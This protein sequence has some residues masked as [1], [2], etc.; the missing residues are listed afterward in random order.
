M[1]API[2]KFFSAGEQQAVYKR[3]QQ[4]P[5]NMEDMRRER[6]HS[7]SS[8]FEQVHDACFD[9]CRT[10]NDLT[11]LSVKEGRCY[12]NCVTK[13][14]Y[15]QPS[16]AGNLRGTAYAHQEEVNAALREKLGRPNPIL[17]VAHW[18]KPGAPEAEE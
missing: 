5:L 14:S 12:R 8:L 10:D 17:S 9:Q 3:V 7:M 11:F 2:D 16:L 6:F 13:I 18:S 4:F 1:E 15:F